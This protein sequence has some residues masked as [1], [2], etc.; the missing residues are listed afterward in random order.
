MGCC[1]LGAAILYSLRSKESQEARGVVWLKAC[2]RDFPSG[3]VVENLPSNAGDLGSIP[4][5]G[6]KIPHAIGQ[7]N[8]HA[9][10]RSPRIPQGRPRT[11]KTE[12]YSQTQK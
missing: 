9:T 11:A 2:L 6:T 4:D 3:S 10:V 5:Q 12:T 8:L 1:G 7:L